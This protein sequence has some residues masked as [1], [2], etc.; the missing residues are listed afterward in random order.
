MLDIS[1][2]AA[3]TKYQP[4]NDDAPKPRQFR[5]SL[6]ERLA[7][8]GKLYPDAMLNAALKVAGDKYYED[9]YGAGMSTLI[10]IDYGRVRTGGGSGG[11]LPVGRLQTQSRERYRAARDTLPDVYR[12]PVDM[13][14]LDGQDDLAAVGVAL[15]GAKCPKT[16][17]AVGLERFKVG[18][19]LL[20]Q[21][22]G[23]LQAN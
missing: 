18:L 5:K 8:Q 11:G 23:L 20:A 13:I 7:E 22:Y 3:K 17:R 15:T 6:L 1:V 12:R 4:A 2:T 10:G 9:W 21:H 16:A 19:F 14:L